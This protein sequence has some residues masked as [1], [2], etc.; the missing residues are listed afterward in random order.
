MRNR[1]RLPAATA[2]LVLASLLLPQTPALAVNKFAAEFLRVG[3]GS[4]ALG[5]GGA[6]TAVADDASAAYWNP[7]GLALL[8]RPDAQFTH[9]EVFG[10]LVNHDVISAAMPIGRET[11][12]ATIGVTL[13]RL[14]VDD[15]K[16]TRD[17]LIEE[18]GG[19]VRVNPSRVRLESAADY[20]LL[21][22]YARRAGDRWSVGGNFKMIR[23]TLVNEG[24][25][26]GIG[27]DLGLLYQAGATTTLGLRAA[28][29]TTTQI[30]WDTGHHETLAPTVT[31]GGQTTLEIPSVRGQLT[32]AAD[33][34]L[35]FENLGDADQFS[36][37]SLSGNLHAGAEFWYNRTVA[38]RLGTDS[39]HFAAGA[40]LRF[41]LGPLQRFGVDYA[42][43]DHDALDSTNRVTLNLGW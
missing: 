19:L 2:A 6:F 10:S 30:K 16:V 25:S 41:R 18:A 13:I 12:N 24:S 36:S 3:V 15:I 35:A 11:R 1:T 8:P 17:A 29:V 21:F 26:F 28:D 27:A 39:G 32:P 43:L 14:G 7:A 22:S 9:A 4:R 37:G 40:G 33:V 23:Q 42:F 34:Q 38:L 20:G 31:L 5:M